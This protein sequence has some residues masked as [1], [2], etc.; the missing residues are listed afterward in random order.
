MKLLQFFLTV[1]SLLPS[2]FV[3]TD[4]QLECYKGCFHKIHRINFE[5]YRPR[6]L[7]IWKDEYDDIYKL[8]LA[9]R[10]NGAAFAN[11]TNTYYGTFF[12]ENNDLQVMAGDVFSYE[13]FFGIEN[14]MGDGYRLETNTNFTVTGKKRMFLLL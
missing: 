12:V 3:A 9:F 6:G 4:D 8:S 5:F 1:F 2:S 10:I 11:V 13:G 14:L 7:K